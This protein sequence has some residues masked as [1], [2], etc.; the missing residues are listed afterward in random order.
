M[1]INQNYDKN[2]FLEKKIFGQIFELLA[3]SEK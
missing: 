1:K 2:T 3:H